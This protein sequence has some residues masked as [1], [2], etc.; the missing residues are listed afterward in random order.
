VPVLGAG[1][2]HCGRNK[3]TSEAVYKLSNSLVL[4]LPRASVEKKVVVVVV[5]LVVVVV[6]RCWWR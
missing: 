2:W 4:L 6:M 3:G 5:V 1:S